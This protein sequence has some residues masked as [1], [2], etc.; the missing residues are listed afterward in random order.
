MTRDPAAVETSLVGATPSRARTPQQARADELLTLYA[1]H[2]D[3]P[4]VAKALRLSLAELEAEVDALHLRRKVGQLVRGS[5]HLM[6]VAQSRPG[7]ESGPSVR[8]RKGGEKPLAKPAEAPP[9]EERAPQRD[10]A[11]SPPARSWGPPD[12][13]L[14]E[15]VNTPRVRGAKRQAPAREPRPA[16]DAKP[17]AP[18]APPLRARSFSTEDLRALLRDFGPRRHR[19]QEA[20][21]PPGKPLPVPLLLNAFRDAGLEREFG[22]RERDLVRGLVSLHKGLFGPVAKELALDLP[23]LEQLVKERG[24]TRELEGVRE[25]YKAQAR[26]KRWPHDQL[27]QLLTERERLED[28]GLFEELKDAAGQRVL[29]SWSRDP[30][31]PQPARLQR[32][33]KEL[34][35]GPADARKLAELLALR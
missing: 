14:R 5:G 15:H 24:L 21:G 9:H 3:T 7:A 28:L 18:K 25:K 19:L 11:P 17:A 4:L 6:P 34:R 26:S 20:M 33:G 2:R 12:G 31:A 32:L 1:Y 13:Q 16:P 10:A 23:R 8:R 29:K 30:Q 35:L 27:A 22:Q